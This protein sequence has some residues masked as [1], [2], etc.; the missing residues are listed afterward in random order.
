MSGETDDFKQDFILLTETEMRVR[1][2][3]QCTQLGKT[4]ISN[5]HEDVWDWEASC[6]DEEQVGGKHR[7]EENITIWERMIE[8]L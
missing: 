8:R 1:Q 4:L 7:D 2:A 5:Q 3:T 6:L